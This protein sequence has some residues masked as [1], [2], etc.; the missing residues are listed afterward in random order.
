MVVVRHAVK[1]EPVQATTQLFAVTDTSKMW[2]WIDIYESDI[3]AVKPGQKV[4]FVVSGNDSPPFSGTV[5]WVG[6]EVSQQTRTTRIR[7]EL[8]NPEGRLRANQFGQAEIQVGDEHKAVIVPKA[9]VQRKD[10]VDLVF[11]PQEEG[12]VY[13]PQR[14]MAK[15][16]DRGDVL[17]VAW[18][19]KPG[20]RVV[21]K[22]AFLLKTEIMKGAI[23]A[24]CCE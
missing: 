24:G 6:T 8:A 22:G 12:G 11:L 1:G 17:E 13:R 4:T 5:N 23:G 2:L 16:T 9:A 20:Q 3:A 14:V 10:G 21:T 18:G 7:A 15:P 19:L